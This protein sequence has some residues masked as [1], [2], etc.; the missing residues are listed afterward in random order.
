MLIDQ[1][2]NDPEVIKDWL[3]RTEAQWE[4][5]YGI[6]GVDI[7]NYLHPREEGNRDFI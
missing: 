4:K 3:K 2:N 5:F 1:L 6:A 7:Y